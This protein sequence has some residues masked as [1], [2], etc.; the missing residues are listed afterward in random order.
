MNTIPLIAILTDFGLSDAYVGTM[1][2]VAL[3]ICPSAHLVDITHAIQPQNV[4]QAA[5][6]LMTA[7]RHFPAHT[8]FLIVVDPG[9]GTARE[10]IA[11]ATDHG[12]YVAPNNGVLSYVLPLL[13][14]QHAVI[15][16]NDAYYHTS[17]SATFHGRDIFSPGAAY[18][19]SGVPITEF[20]PTV[21]ELVELPDPTLTVGSEQIT[22][23][24]IHIDHF[25]NVITSIGQLQWTAPETLELAPQ[26]GAD[27]DAV[28]AVDA[29][30]SR[31]TV[32]G[33]TLDRIHRTYGAV[34]PGTMTV[35]VGSSGQLE[36]GVNQGSAAQQL[37]AKLGDIVTLDLGG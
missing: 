11:V 24:V 8:V 31:I 9:V 22:G 20:G 32:R 3:S 33:R 2:G 5:Y 4:R 29:A 12:I 30:R 28:C 27:R 36:I 18:L 26:F 15:L 13:N 10:P 6:V 7:Y 14:V 19:A 23:E 17:R 1:K 21:P 16:Q 35:L 34:D 37:N 25:G